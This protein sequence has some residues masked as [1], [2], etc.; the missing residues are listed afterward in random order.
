MV[1]EKVYMWMSIVRGRD[2]GRVQ[3]AHNQTELAHVKEEEGKGEGK[4]GNQV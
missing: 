1:G 4:K 2:I 3:S